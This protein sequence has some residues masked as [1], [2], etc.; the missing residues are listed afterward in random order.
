[1]E[2]IDQAFA[3]KIA[4]LR[5]EAN[6]TPTEVA[7]ALDLWA[8]YYLDLENGKARLD[9]A[10]DLNFSRLAE[11]LRGDEQEL[12]TLAKQSE[13]PD[14]FPEIPPKSESFE[15]VEGETFF[16]IP[17]FD[18]SVCLKNMARRYRRIVSSVAEVEWRLRLE[19]WK[20]LEFK[21]CLSHR[22]ERAHRMKEK[23]LE[24]IG[25]WRRW[26]TEGDPDRSELAWGKA[27]RS[28]V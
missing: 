2:S 24:T 12:R 9:P 5:L 28:G 22:A 8:T 25:R 11:V 14:D 10:I 27:R 7:Y 6:K 23:I 18:T 20:K 21:Y 16:F 1:M 17:G 15:V 4:R 26:S 19:R 13:I 3:N